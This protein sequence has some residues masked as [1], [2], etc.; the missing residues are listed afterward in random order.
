MGYTP[1]EF[2]D[3]ALSRV[4]LDETD[5]IE[6]RELDKMAEDSFVEL[7]DLLIR[8]FEDDFDTRVAS[9]ETVV[10][11]RSYLVPTD[12]WRL[13]RV[14]LIMPNG[15]EV[16]LERFNRSAGIVPARSYSW[17]HQTVPRY[18]LDFK[19]AGTTSIIFNCRP[20]AVVTI[21]LHY[22]PV[23]TR[24]RDGAEGSTV[25]IA[26]AP[27]VESNDTLVVPADVDFIDAELWGGGA[28]AGG[29]DGVALGGD[30]GGGAYVS[31]TIPVVPGETLTIRTGGGGDAGG[32]STATG[33]DA[34]G[35]GGGFSAI[36]R[37][38][39]VTQTAVLLLAAG[40]GGGGG[41][42]ATQ[43]GGD[44]APGGALTGLP[45][46]TPVGGAEGG[47]G[48]TQ[49]AGG[50][51][52]NATAGGDGTSGTALQGGAG[53][54]TGAAEGGGGSGLSLYGGDGAHGSA[55]NGG[56][57]G[58]GG[59]YFGGGG[60]EGGS[61]GPGAGGGS[62]SSFGP[63]NS[64]MDQGTG[65]T[66]PKTESDVY[67]RHGL[68]STR[69]YGGV[70]QTNGSLGLSVVRYVTGRVELPL[71]GYDEYPLLD[72][73]IK[74]CGKEGSDPSVFL[75]QKAGIEERIKNRAGPKD[76][77]QPEY[78][79]DIRSLEDGGDLVGDPGFWDT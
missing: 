20:A 76:R 29:N 22:I 21:N 34:G 44:G 16:P 23:A 69:G 39:V 60:G 38:A 61:A 35:E 56:G 78:L 32:G 65:V 70:N 42:T 46:E 68:S 5:Y 71:Y 49:L 73:L 33:A 59:G 50:E 3:A 15:E 10:D 31:A 36:F 37:G 52:G 43:D 19:G 75:A 12:C 62:G 77:G 79:A 58:A 54:L 72:V 41:A 25:E 13:V 27:V 8:V 64:Y 18:S 66:P 74:I 51:G 47:S 17:G 11:E 28:G 53:G 45:G 67:L 26:Y 7:H 30:G 24:M 2:R 14:G 57:G 6:T 63:S 48:G 4:D 9:F 1:Q 55:A 40:G